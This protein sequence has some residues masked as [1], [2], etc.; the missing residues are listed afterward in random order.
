MT[1]PRSWRR[2]NCKLLWEPYHNLR[3]TMKMTQLRSWRR[4]NCKLVRK[5]YHGLRNTTIM[6]QPRSWRRCS[7]KLPRES[8]HGL[9]SIMKNV[10]RRSWK[11]ATVNSHK[12]F[13][14]TWEI[15]WRRRNYPLQWEVTKTRKVH[16]F[17]FVLMIYY[18][19]HCL[20]SYHCNQIFFLLLL[21]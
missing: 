5:P 4:C 19:S 6:M 9:G 14:M 13:I 17:D 18:S 1:Q 2:Y 3:S 16:S 21:L 11:E 15:Q 8:Y 7:R 20:R 12:G 10:Q